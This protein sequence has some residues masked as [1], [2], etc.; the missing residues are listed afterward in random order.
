MQDPAPFSACFAGTTKDGTPAENGFL[1][2]GQ[3]AVIRQM[4]ENSAC[5]QLVDGLG[6]DVRHL[7]WHESGE[8]DGVKY[9]DGQIRF[10]G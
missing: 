5:S 2:S 8:P 9:Q 6:E 3:E 7:R 1:M 4:K 10:I